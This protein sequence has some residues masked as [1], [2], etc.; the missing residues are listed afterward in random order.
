MH[1]TEYK[2]KSAMSLVR[3]AFHLYSLIH[4]K[5]KDGRSITRRRDKLIELFSRSYPMMRTDEVLRHSQD[6]EEVAREL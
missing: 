6:L 5:R 3:G 1:P 2:L 4:T